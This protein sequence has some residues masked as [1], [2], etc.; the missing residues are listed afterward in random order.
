MRSRG[1]SGGSSWVRR[2]SCLSGGARVAVERG[3]ATVRIEDDDTV[4]CFG[5]GDLAM[6]GEAAVSLIDGDVWFGRCGLGRG[7]EWGWIVMEAVCSVMGFV[8]RTKMGIMVV[9]SCCEGDADETQLAEILIE[10]RFVFYFPFSYDNPPSRS[11]LK[12]RFIFINL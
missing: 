9:L 11:Y 10:K 2:D 8:T 7:R 6:Q 5:E 3:D 12:P 1:S 4:L